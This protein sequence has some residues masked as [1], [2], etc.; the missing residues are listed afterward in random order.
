MG[1]LTDKEI[2]NAPVWKSDYKMSEPGG[3]YLLV[4]KN[5]SKWWRF[6]YS[7][8][9]VERQIAMG[10]YPQVSLAQVR[11]ACNE[12]R[13][14]IAKGIKPL[15]ARKKEKVEEKEAEAAPPEKI[16]FGVMAAEWYE[17]MRR[18]GR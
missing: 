16:T 7:I 6:R 2:K 14:L 12:A 18:P 11:A 8:G 15:E 10:V 9:G 13:V 17:K 1:P 4:K 5:G 3:L